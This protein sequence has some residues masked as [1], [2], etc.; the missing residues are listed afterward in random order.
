MQ[1]TGEICYNQANLSDKL[2]VVELKA[3]Y[4]ENAKWLLSEKAILAGILIYTVPEYRGMWLTEVIPLIGDDTQVA[5]APVSPGET[6][7]PS[8]LGDNPVN[9]IPNEGK[10]TFDVRFHAWLPGKQTRIKLLIDVEAQKDYFPGYDIVTRGVFYTARMI[11]AQLGTEFTD[12]DYNNIKKVYSI[13]ICTHVPKYAEN[14]VT[15]YSMSQKNIVGNFPLN[16]S[17]YD[18]QSVIVIGL[19]ETLAGRA[20]GEKVHRLL[21]AIFSEELSVQEK[22]SILENEFHLPMT[23]TMDRRVENMCNLSEAIEERGIK[24]GIEKGRT[25]GNIAALISIVRNMMRKSI[26]SADIAEISGK[27]SKLV[28]QLCR[29]ISENQLLSDDELAERYINSK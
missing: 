5:E 19:A 27:D 28:E 3:A 25:Q 9:E 21:G 2:S 4:D 29:M 16:K 18:L 13:W 7:M 20:E 26:P 10:I 15:E 24:K 17:R 12:S 8:V 6:N 11:S 14:T 1:V 22:K 23:Q